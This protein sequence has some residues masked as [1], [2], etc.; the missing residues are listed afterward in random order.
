MKPD[1]LAIR[2]VNRLVWKT[3]FSTNQPTN[4]KPPELHPR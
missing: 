4:E 2:Q 3:D 1:N